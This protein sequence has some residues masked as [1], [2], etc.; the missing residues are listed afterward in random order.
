[1]A[2]EAGQFRLEL[3]GRRIERVRFEDDADGHSWT[4]LTLDTGQEV[5]ILDETP[6]V[7]VD[8]EVM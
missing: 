6:W 4:I 3:V 8:P 1:M 2:I 7:W 5:Q